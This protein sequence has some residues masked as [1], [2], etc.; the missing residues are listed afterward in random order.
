ML[1]QLKACSVP[2]YLLINNQQF[3]NFPEWKAT[4]R[5]DRFG[6]GPWGIEA[7]QGMAKAPQTRKSRL[8]LADCVRFSVFDGLRSVPNGRSWLV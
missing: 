2:D 7:K 6:A 3:N 8:G 5:A 1:K 4:R